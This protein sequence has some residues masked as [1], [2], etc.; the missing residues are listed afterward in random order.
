[1]FL[2][3]IVLLSL[4]ITSSLLIIDNSTSII[5]SYLKTM[6]FAEKDGNRR[7]GLVNAS[8]PEANDMLIDWGLPFKKESTFQIING[9][10]IEL[11]KNATKMD[12]VII[13]LEELHYIDRIVSTL[14][15]QPFFKFSEPNYHFL[16]LK[17]YS[18]SLEE[19]DMYMRQL[20]ENHQLV[21]F[22]IIFMDCFN[23]VQIISY[24]PFEAKAL[25][26]SGR[27]YSSDILF[28]N[29]LKDL[30][31]YKIKISIFKKKYEAEFINNSC[32]KGRD[33]QIMNTFLKFFNAR[34]DI[35][36]PEGSIDVA[37]NNVKKDIISGKSEIAF[38]NRWLLPEE[39]MHGSYSVRQ[40]AIVGIVPRAKRRPLATS[41]A[42]IFDIHIWLLLILL[43]MIFILMGNIAKASGLNN[44]KISRKFILLPTYFYSLIFSN[45]FQGAVITALTS[46]RYE[47]DI[48]SIEDL[49]RSGL[50][51]CGEQS[52][53]PLLK[54]NLNVSQM[55]F[56]E[57]NRV[58]SS[59]K[60]NQAY[61][62]NKIWAL[63][64]LT[65]IAKTGK[66]Y[67]DYYHVS[68]EAYGVGTITYYL[69]NHTPYRQTFRQFII[70]M[71]QFGLD[72]PFPD[73]G[74]RHN[75]NRKES[76]FEVLTLRQI[77]IAFQIWALGLVISTVIFVLEIVCVG[78]KPKLVFIR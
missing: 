59:T 40:T 77:K 21:D 51:V 42:L 54:D 9:P 43:K 73:V 18:N 16:V 52:W 47:P 32:T 75:I 39:Y 41:L 55:S 56:V 66:F 36:E 62:V 67:S 22:V 49:A 63:N 14:I 53:S 48:D 30:K 64:F 10:T 28:P 60:G 5:G 44:N 58:L 7:I 6:N 29:K 61:M 72:L 12:H 38:N 68:K 23:N 50:R 2:L 11:R 3:A 71:S 1:M 25:N 31:G 74:K 65:L 69:G 70:S 24:N 8:L 33:C 4:P 19:L 46:L 35:V 26:Y 27:E 15:H 45:L 20:W 57:V 76:T 78:K 37:Y 34:A 13:F 17:P